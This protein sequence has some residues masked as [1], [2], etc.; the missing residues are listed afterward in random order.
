[1]IVARAVKTYVNVR[2]NEHIGVDE[3]KPSL[4]KMY[5]NRLTNTLFILTKSLFLE[6]SCFVVGVL[7]N[8]SFIP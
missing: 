6:Y 4:N 1:M 8:A 2:E 3:L 7:R 5:T